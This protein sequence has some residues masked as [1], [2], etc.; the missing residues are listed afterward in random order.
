M[1]HRHETATR[2]G[3]RWFRSAAATDAKWR[4]LVAFIALALISASTPIGSHANAAGA[5]SRNLSSSDGFSGKPAVARAGDTTYVAWLELGQAFG[6]YR[7]SRITDSGD[8]SGSL[9]LPEGSGHR[10]LWH[11]QIAV[12]G[13]SVH[14]VWE[15]KNEDSNHWGIWLASSTDGGSGWTLRMI[16]GGGSGCCPHA[17]ARPD[18]GWRPR[19]AAAGDRVSVAY[20][21]QA[22]EVRLWSG[23]A[24]GGDGVNRFV[25]SV[26]GGFSADAWDVAME[27]ASTFVAVRSS[28]GALN[29]FRYDGA[30]LTPGAQAFGA[31]RGMLGIAHPRLAVSGD[32]VFVAYAAEPSTI[33][34]VGSAD[35]GASFGPP[36]QV[37]TAASPCTCREL[38]IAATQDR[39]NVIW[40]G[41]AGMFERGFGVGGIGPVNQV[42]AIPDAEGAISSTA[43]G[44]VVALAAA[45][46]VYS[47]VRR[48]GES[49]FAVRNVSETPDGTSFSPDIAADHGF[50]GMAWREWPTWDTKDL[51]VYFHA[52]SLDPPDL[53]I[54][55]SEVVQSAYGV[56]RLVKNKPSLI[57]IT[58][59]SA[60]PRRAS[61]A[62]QLD[63][64]D[65]GT[66]TRSIETFTIGPGAQ[67]VFL[68]DRGSL[69]PQGDLSYTVTLDPMGSIDEVDETNNTYSRDYKVKDTRPFKALVVPIAITGEGAS[70]PSDAEVEAMAQGTERF[71]KAAFPLDP[72]EVEVVAQAGTPLKVAN[73]MK[74]P[75]DM[76]ND[77]IKP[78]D[79]MNP[80][81]TYDSILGVPPEGWL[82]SHAL[83]KERQPWQPAPL[84]MAFSRYEPFDYVGSPSLFFGVPKA[85][86]VDPIGYGG[87]EAAHEI[88]HQLGWVTEGHPDEDVPGNP[89][90]LIELAAPGNWVS[91][92]LEVRDKLD[93][94]YNSSAGA[95]VRVSTDRWISP[96]TWDFLLNR[97]AIDPID[98]LS[99]RVSGTIRPDGSVT[100]GTW[101]QVEGILDAS[102]GDA[103]EIGLRYIDA[104]G[105]VIGETGFNTADSMTTNPHSVASPD[106]EAFSATVPWVPG[107]ETIELTDHDGNPI[108]SRAM[109]ASAPQVEVFPDGGET[110]RVGDNVTVRWVAS[111]ADG[112]ALSSVVSMSLD[113]GTT[114]RPLGADVTS[115]SFDFRVTRDMESDEALV[116]VETSDGL[117][118]GQ[119]Q[120]DATFRILNDAQPA[121]LLYAADDTGAGGH[122]FTSEPDGANKTQMTAGNANWIDADW[123]P[124]GT[125][126]AA[127]WDGPRFHDETL[128]VL[129][130]APNG[131]WEPA[132]QLTFTGTG[133]YGDGD[134]AWSPDGTKIA[135]TRNVGAPV[136]EQVGIINADGTGE[137]L[138][139]GRGQSPAWSPDGTRIAFERAGDIYSVSV[140]GS[141]EQ[142][143]TSESRWGDHTG[144]PAWSPDG[145]WIAVTYLRTAS[146]QR[147][148]E[149]ALVRLGTNFGPYD[150]TGFRAR[151]RIR[152]ILDGPEWSPDGRTVAFAEV[153]SGTVN[154]SLMRI[155]AGQVIDKILAGAYDYGD[156]ATFIPGAC[157]GV[158]QG[159]SWLPGRDGAA[160]P[161]R[162]APVADVGGPYTVDE[163]GTANLDGSGSTVPDGP[164]TY[165]WD[166]DGDGSYDDASGQSASFE[167]KD[168][169]YD[170]A[171]LAVT[172]FYGVMDTQQVEIDVRN[173][174]PEISNLVATIDEDGMGHVSADFSDAGLEDTHTA[175]V[176]WGDGSLPEDVSIIDGEGDSA[177]AGTYRYA[178]PGPFQVTLTVTDDDGGAADAA[179]DVGQLPSNSAPV[180]RDVVASTDQGEPVEIALD[181]SDSDAGPQPLQVEIVEAPAHGRVFLQEPAES[182]EGEVAAVYIPEDAF[183]GND[184]FTYRASD[185]R[186]TSDVSVASIEVRGTEATPTPSAS[187]APP[188]SRPGAP[189]PE[190]PSASPSEGPSAPPT[191]ATTPAPVPSSGADPSP[192]P[193]APTPTPAPTPTD[194]PASVPPPAEP[195]CTL[196]GTAGNDVLRGSAGDD[197]ICGGGGHDRLIGLS[198]DDELR[199]G[200]GRDILLG[201]AGRDSLAGGAA[202]DRVRGGAGVDRG[203]GGG[204]RDRLA[205]GLGHDRLAGG[206]GNDDLAGGPGRDRLVGGPGRD[207]LAGGLGSDTLIGGNA[208][209][210]GGRRAGDTCV[211]APRARPRRC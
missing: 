21:S 188:Q 172:D 194:A 60:L 100:T 77:I 160:V 75:V 24:A 180:A 116:R 134:P 131:I 61:V 32:H 193:T 105:A 78:L 8:T 72:L 120:S 181:M 46:E 3:G 89:A 124:D 168:D 143:L 126:I 4:G 91:R 103:G 95:D 101:Y 107:T 133:S 203:R 169:D 15:Q 138:L 106:F 174:A 136:Y 199:G 128:H 73:G 186:D 154:S 125:K 114:W 149:I 97:F 11:P 140:D 175:T 36:T 74:D 119:D 71:I 44:V 9:I 201:R 129:E 137:V 85:V 202:A 25:S 35:R 58:V 22:D 38:D 2:S 157:C 132:S 178:T 111:D 47:A 42:V 1:S 113:G 159:V 155:E 55:G 81:N 45:G 200:A 26:S 110:F 192:T 166:L 94:M 195:A 16:S 31:D 211:P 53:S 109:T 6:G 146:G 54:L 49:T 198:G 51:E 96:Q 80:S 99:V 152:T 108:Y 148:A 130:R 156:P 139:P 5:E 115:D 142:Q 163:G 57:R 122:L 13:S 182:G 210:S 70:R 158:H 28:S 177:V 56:D 189:P 145:K 43:N 90:H 173:A 207:R 141:D 88:T 164:G 121:R 37:S 144:D 48:K 66:E 183:A 135:F 190:S 147:Y 184:R 204:G 41:T 63:L 29:I 87:W 112:D 18:G 67:H 64:N 153:S 208:G 12:S 104:A 19:L 102:L 117:R 23:A 69:Q 84:G 7:V 165:A 151:D 176:D 34:Q 40:G 33:Y 59:R 65:G 79:G 62:V 196:V 68:P 206:R 93:W 205:G 123:S 127:R 10:S 118:T 162:Q 150:I 83:T 39:A 209:G 92:R 52:G 170:T 98:P 191:S 82:G 185:G 161:P 17:A 187:A 197:V 50:F 179:S 14:V 86:I 76:W 171:A 167:A 20:V 30:G 27:G